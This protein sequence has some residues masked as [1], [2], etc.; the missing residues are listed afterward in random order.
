MVGVAVGAVALGWS[1]ERTADDAA[2]VV[3]DAL[4]SADVV[5]TVSAPIKAS[6]YAPVDA[7]RGPYPVWRVPVLVDEAVIHIDV[8][9]ETG[10]V[11]FV[12]DLVGATGRDR[13]LTDAQ[14][15]TVRDLAPVDPW[16]ERNGIASAAALWIVGVVFVLAR[17]R[18]RDRERTPAGVAVSRAVRREAAAAS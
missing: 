16:L 3:A 7:D 4:R 1:S 17:T 18:R 5:A 2:D 14:W 10:D 9:R 12:D 11:V 15:E 8:H 13:A 6:E